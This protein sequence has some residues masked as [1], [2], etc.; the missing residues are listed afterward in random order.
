MKIHAIS[1]GSVQIRQ[2]MARSVSGPARR[3]AMFTGPW[4]EWLPI[5]AWAIEHAD[6]VVLVD[7]GERCGVRDAPFARF[8][9]SPEQEIVPQLRTAGVDPAALH[10]VVL[11][12]L[13]GDHMDG[14]AS[15]SPP[16]VLI[17]AAEARAAAGIAVRATRA[18]IR[19]PLPD[20][21]A[22]QAIAFDGPAIGAFPASHPVTADGTIS[23]VPAPG[24]TSGHSAV[25]L[26]ED[27]LH[28]LLAGDC[29]YDQ[30]QLLDQHVDAVSP[31]ASLARE[32]MRTVLA[33]AAMHPTVYLPSHDP[34]S[35]GRLAQRA[36]LEPR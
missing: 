31:R 36:V 15:L 17:S 14:L 21:F 23:L 25:L 4:S 3:L 16:R 28:I 27:D 5:H 2:R 1:T 10:T 32:T 18:L 24:H 8:R 22:P 34:G 11:T 13:H 30:Q 6:G 35:A 20:D 33:H 19:Q 9:I 26:V 12:H 29:S 7:T